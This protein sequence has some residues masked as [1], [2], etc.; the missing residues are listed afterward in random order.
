MFTQVW[1]N[2]TGIDFS[3]E[4]LGWAANSFYM[5]VYY[6][7]T[8]DIAEMSYYDPSMTFTESDNIISGKKENSDNTLYI[9]R[10]GD[11]FFYYEA[12]Y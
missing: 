7:P 10:L 11:G 6:S 12:S 9:E 3:G 4:G 5:G 8:G 1:A 2:E